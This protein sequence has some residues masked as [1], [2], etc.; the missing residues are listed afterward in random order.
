VAH[1]SFDGGEAMRIPLS[2][3]RTGQYGT[4]TAIE[5]IEPAIE[6]PK[7]ARTVSVWVE[8]H[9]YANNAWDSDFGKNY[10]FPVEP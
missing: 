5:P 6:V 1:V 7:D 10:T 2:A 8:G 9:A 3:V 4:H